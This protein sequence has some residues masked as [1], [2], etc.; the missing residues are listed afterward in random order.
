MMCDWLKS[1][2]EIPDDPEM[3][4]DLCGVQ[5]GFSNKGQ[6]QYEKKTD[7]KARGLAS[8][9]LGD[10]LA[11]TFAEK[12]AKRIGKPDPDPPHWKLRYPGAKD[13]SWM[14]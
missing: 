14:A 13:L 7:M 10:A 2:A 8:P 1:G 11:M 12:I 5:Y 9:D 6:I 4:T 3:E